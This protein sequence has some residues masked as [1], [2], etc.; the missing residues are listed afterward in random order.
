MHVPE[1]EFLPPGAVVSVNYRL[2]N[3]EN[4]LLVPHGAVS[5]DA[6]SNNAFLYTFDS[7]THKVSKKT[8]KIVDIQPIGYLISTELEP[9]E[10]Y[11]SAGAAFIHDGQPVRIFGEK[12]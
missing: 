1:G 8:A 11:V 5:V 4:L 10:R 2:K 12:D 3:S 9:G 7:E 6:T